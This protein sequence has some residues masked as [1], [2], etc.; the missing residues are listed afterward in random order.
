MDHGFL[1]YA[2]P[3]EAFAAEQGHA[4]KPPQLYQGG[5]KAALK[6]LKD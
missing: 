5:V 1:D 6:F 3:E 2:T 4:K